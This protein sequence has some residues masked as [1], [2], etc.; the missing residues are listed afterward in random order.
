ME[1]YHGR[2]FIQHTKYAYVMYVVFITFIYG[3]VMPV[4]F[5]IGFLNLFMF[6]YT[7]RYAMFYS[8]KKPPTFD[9]TLTKNTIKTMYWAPV[10]YLAVGCYAFSN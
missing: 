10:F 1:L 4:M 3:A 8:Y 5:P 7:E 6:Y 9:D 2:E